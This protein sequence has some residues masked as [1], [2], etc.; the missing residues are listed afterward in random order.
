MH[1]FITL[2]SLGMTDS[3]VC[4]LM[5]GHIQWSWQNPSLTF[6]THNSDNSRSQSLEEPQPQEIQGHQ[7]MGENTKAA[8]VILGKGMTHPGPRKRDD[9][10][11]WNPGD[12]DFGQFRPRDASPGAGRSQGRDLGEYNQC[13]PSG[14]SRRRQTA[15]GYPLLTSPKLPRHSNEVLRDPEGR[16]MGRNPGG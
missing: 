14:N 4:C 5:K 6:G 11:F 10:S 2:L 3:S 9:R 16:R 13:A 8:A 1:I 7:V 12:P 15:S